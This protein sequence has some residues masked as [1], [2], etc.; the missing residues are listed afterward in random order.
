MRN[1]A[2]RRNL[3]PGP[4]RSRNRRRTGAP[5]ASPRRT[6]NLLLNCRGLSLSRKGG[7][8]RVSK[9]RF[10]NRTLNRP[11]RSLPGRKRHRPGRLLPGRRVTK[12]SNPPTLNPAWTSLCPGAKSAPMTIPKSPGALALQRTLSR[13]ASAC[14]QP[15]K[16]CP[17]EA[18]AFRGCP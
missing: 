4:P 8:C 1:A 16:D 13:G 5:S 12:N 11:G 3:L 15:R 10:L 14:G 6:G 17:Q 9:M 7:V 2:L 18:K